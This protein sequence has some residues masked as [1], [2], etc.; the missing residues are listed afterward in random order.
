MTE[1]TPAPPPAE[2]PVDPLF[3]HAAAPFL[4]TEVP[5]P[6][7]FASPPAPPS[8]LAS[9]WVTYKTQIQLGLMFLAFLMV[10]VGT[11]TVVQANQ[12]V[13]WRYYIALLP[14]VP[15]GLLLWLFLRALGRLNELQKWIQ[16][17]AFGFA[18]GATAL[19]T[20]GYG[21]LEGAGMPQLNWTL[22]LPLMVILWALGSAGLA[23]RQ[24]YRR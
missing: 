13:Q 22:V 20:F 24:R 2:A 10:V 16:F 21:F 4:R 18:L 9:S 12:A 5:A 7:A 3:T 11:A 23:L 17:Q 15:A 6:V 8:G 1:Q 19:L 14:A